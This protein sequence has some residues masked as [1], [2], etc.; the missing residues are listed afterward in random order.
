MSKSNQKLN[1][2]T[3]SDKFPLT[4]HKTGQYCKKIK[5]KI[6]YFGT[7]KQ[8][9]YQKYI[10]QASSL[11]LNQ[12]IPKGCEQDLSIKDL[13]NM[14]LD[15]QESRISSGEIKMRQFYDQTRQLKSF[16]VFCGASTPV[17]SITTID[18]QAYRK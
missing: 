11:H 13:C 16:V 7:N 9:A 17:S 8:A 1:R 2:K 12:K 5:G 15:Y 6:F 4:L 10:E 14:Y 3:R 18:L